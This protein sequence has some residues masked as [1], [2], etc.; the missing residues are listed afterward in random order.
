MSEA[1]ELKQLVREKYGAIAE[2]SKAENKDSGCGCG[3]SSSSV[4]YTVLA[5][6]YSNLSGY[7]EDADL[8]LGCGLPTEFAQIMA[9]NTV[10][11][12]GSGA[13]NDA[14]VARAIVGDTGSVIGIDMT[15]EMIDKARNNAAKLNFDNVE[16]RLGDIEAMPLE[17]ASVDVVVS[18]CVMNL[19]PDKQKA[20]AETYRII[21]PG[22]HFSISD[23]VLEGELPDS[24][25]K[26]AEMYVGCVS[27][28]QRM[29]DY[30][31]TIQNAGFTNVTV[32]KKKEIALPDESL[33]EY[34]TKE[35]LDAARKQGAG[36]Y[37]ITVYAEKPADI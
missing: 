37:S 4:D 26:S 30:L 22:G 36:I 2:H 29:T 10:V 14:F 3:C 15:P 6:N 12:L 7:V 23:I 28:A 8:G 1:N 24:V 9:G 25:R 35:E 33:L 19:V 31:E 13:G 20:F 16:F 17:D 34:L 27:G 18:N 32:Q 11:D 21:K 5:D